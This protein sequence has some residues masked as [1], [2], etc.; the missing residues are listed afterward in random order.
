MGNSN[1]GV[2]LTSG[3]VVS[4]TGTGEN[5]ASISI[6]GT[7]GEGVS[8]NMGV[9]ILSSEIESVDGAIA[10]TGNGGEAT[11]DKNLGILLSSAAKIT[12]TGTGT[13]AAAIT[14]KGT[15]G[16]GE[17]R[18]IGVR[19]SGGAEVTSTDGNIELDG[20]G[21]DAAATGALNLGTLITS[22]ASVT[23]S[24]AT[25]DAATITIKGTGGDGV[26]RNSGVWIGEGVEIV[27]QL[28]DISITGLG[29]LGT[30]SL[31]MGV[32]LTNGA[33]INSTGE[34]DDAANISITGTGRGLG[35]ASHRND[36][37][38][39]RGMATKIKSVDGNLLVTGNAGVGT[40]VDIK[41]VKA[42]NVEITGEG[43]ETFVGTVDETT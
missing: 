3:A 30:G 1:L 18:N 32:F 4:S 41:L 2:L 25:A 12:S 29:G 33:L 24:G 26:S 7:G 20:K 6:T 9:W 27:S 23:S 21:G 15:G 8:Q 42:D 35:G 5:A 43:E 36:G 38:R 31:N 37:V 11:G 40:S 16:T 13:N 10:I 34:D 14:L 17:K 22:D 19:L 28:G 39:V